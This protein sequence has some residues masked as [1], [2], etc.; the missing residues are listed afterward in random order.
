[1]KRFVIFLL[2]VALALRA[3]VAAAGPE[4]LRFE[5]SMDAMGSTYSIIVYGSDRARILGAVEL[6][7]DEVKR[8]DQLL[9]NYRPASEWSQVNRYAAE[10]PVKVSSELFNLLAACVEYS[11]L[12]DGAFDISV[13]PLMKVWGFYKGSGH[14]PHR[15]EVRGALSKVGYQN[16]ILDPKAQTVQFRQPGVEIDPG[17]IGK[18]YAVDRMAAV[19]KEYGVTAGLISG[20]GSSIYAIGT[21]PDEKRGWRVSIRNPRDESKT[22]QDVFLKDESMSTSGSYEKFFRAEGRIYSHIMDPRTGFPAA[23]M[24][25][26]SIVAP[27][28]IDSEAWAKP[29]FIDGLKK[30]R[31]W[32]AEFKSKGFR[33]Y[34]CEDRSELSCAW[35]Q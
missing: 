35:L 2:L 7:F 1:V 33:V 24:L 15:A 9:S 29:F 34:L 10:R 5:E 25:S 4:I 28:T 18:G 27:K 22:V 20:S 26:V 17:G 12:S 13:G 19:L 16:L 8:L 30:G 3:P 21:P 14:L 6:A 32:A 11:R 23:G 31:Q